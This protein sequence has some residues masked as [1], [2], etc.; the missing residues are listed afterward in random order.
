MIRPVAA[1]PRPPAIE[2]VPARVRVVLGGQEIAATDAAWRILE[3]YHPPTYYIPRDAFASGVL[4]PSRRTS[5]C[6]W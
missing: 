5:F 6:E 3:T 1:F 2:P 4:A